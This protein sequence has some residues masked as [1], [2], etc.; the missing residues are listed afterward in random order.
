[1]QRIEFQPAYILHRRPYRETSQILELFCRDYGRIGVVAKGIR[2]P[3]SP[4]KGLLQPFI[5]LLISCCGKGELLTLTHFDSVGVW[6]F[7][8]GRRLVSAFY[9]N[10]LLM[11]LL[12]RFDA[13]PDLFQSYDTALIELGK[14]N[15]VA[16]GQAVLRI[17][18][19]SLLKTLGYE[20]QLG[21]EVETGHVIEAEDLYHFD[22]ALGPKLVPA[23]YSYNE[24]KYHHQSNVIFKGKSLLALDQ[25]QLTEGW[26]LSDA[27]RLMRQAL[28]PH[29]GVRPLESRRLL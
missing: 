21:K 18:E 7:L 16:D 6:P 8:M 24:D 12:Y 20:L 17:F 29:L 25:E 9:L 3:K 2:R 10:E 23:A 27:K 26:A 11:R 1:M 19:K 4:A 15:L 13:N 28:A 22:P 14:L 5:P